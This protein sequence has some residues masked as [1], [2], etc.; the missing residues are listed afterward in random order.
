MSAILAASLKLE[1]VQVG[2]CHRYK[3]GQL[4][5]HERPHRVCELASAFVTK[6]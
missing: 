5:L 2:R 6:V 1:W 4:H 3:T